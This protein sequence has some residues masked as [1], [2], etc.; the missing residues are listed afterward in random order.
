MFA[1]VD[2]EVISN[3]GK[4][5]RM[6]AITHLRNH[7][8]AAQTLRKSRD[9]HRARRSRHLGA[10]HGAA[11]L[12]ASSLLAATF[13]SI[14]AA[15]AATANVNLATAS[16]YAVL[17]GSTITNTGPSVIAGDIGLSPGT[18]VTG[19]PPG[20]Q[21]SGAKHITDGPAA[22][23]KSDLTTAYLDAA[24]R[25]PFTTIS[26]DLGGTTLVSGVYKSASS[27]SLTGSVT[28]N[29]G[30]NPA[31]VFIFQAGS[32]LIAASGSQVVLENGAQAC[33]VFWQVGS[34]ATLGTTSRFS[35][36]ILAL[37]S[38]TL[39]T[40]ANVSGRVQARNGAVTLDDNVI[41]APTCAAVT[42]TTTTTDV[43]TSPTT[44]TATA[45]TTIKSSTTTTTTA[46]SK[47]ATTT[48]KP[49]TTT[50]LG[51]ISGTTTTVPHT[52]TSPVTTTTTSTT[53]SSPTT[54]TTAKSVI[55]SGPPGTGFGGA[56]GS[57]G[58]SR[59]PFILGSLALAGL[60]GGLAFN[61][62]RRHQDRSEGSDGRS[63][64]L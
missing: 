30:G 15:G 21:S 44:T 64:E 57:A 26:A 11:L 63:P 50:T 45:S 55:P 37:T 5:G 46:K 10:R 3:S 28:L 17:A 32:S 48:T 31:A 61:Q 29:G 38:I 27:I 35:G 1:V 60:F 56:A 40:G 19:F 13:W 7:L 43:S 4:W 52:T 18:A 20:V 8:I 12:A 14:P 9:V 36:S 25:T 59:T 41:T 16:S 2:D 24:G 6:S 33:H 54:T 47:A 23:A 58:L 42:A 39:D 49:S 34:S 22:A 51:P 62:R 53:T